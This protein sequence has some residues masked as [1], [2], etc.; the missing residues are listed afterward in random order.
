MPSMY[1]FQLWC[2]LSSWSTRLVPP[3]RQ[4]VQ[5]DVMPNVSPPISAR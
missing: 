4:E 3:T 2:A 1:A 5:S